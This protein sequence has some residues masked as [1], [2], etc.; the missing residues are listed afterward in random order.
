MDLTEIHS[1]ADIKG[2]SIDELEQLA[3][4]LRSVLLTKL[5][6][7]GGHTGPNLGFLDA[8]IAMHYVFN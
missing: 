6:T 2:M 7:H 8:T 3:D 4:S 1:P 5:S